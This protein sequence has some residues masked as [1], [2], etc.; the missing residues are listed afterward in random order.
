MKFTKLNIRPTEAVTV[1]SR[2]YGAKVDA[3]AFNLTFI[4]A[5][6]VELAKHLMEMAERARKVE[7]DA[8]ANTRQDG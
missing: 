2:I 6:D 8:K 4:S 3:I 7:E 1:T 5:F